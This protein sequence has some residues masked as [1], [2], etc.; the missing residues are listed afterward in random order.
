MPSITTGQDSGWTGDAQFLVSDPDGTYSQAAVTLYYLLYTTIL[1]NI[2]YR[3]A[4]VTGV[5][6]KTT[7]QTTLFTVPNTPVTTGKKFIVTDILVR[8]DT[9][10]TV[11]VAPIIRVGKSAG[12]T[13]YITTA[14]LTGLDAVGEYKYLSEYMTGADV[15]TQFDLGDVIKLDV[16]TGA[17]ATTL[18]AD[19]YL[20]GIFI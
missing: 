18:T 20:F 2:P 6:L 17:T 10:N 19:F 4:S 8:V 3:Y 7:G 12:Y 11:T 15:H 14:T 13:E 9:A 16:T 5:D 1:P